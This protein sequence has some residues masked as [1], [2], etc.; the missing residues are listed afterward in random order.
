MNKL[1]IPL[2]LAS[3]AV[4]AG[5]FFGGA[6]AV[7]AA[8]DSAGQEPA[9]AAPTPV[10]DNVKHTPGDIDTMIMIHRGWSV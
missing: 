6:I 9:V 8:P 7:M 2:R 10:M 5:A 1:R 4:V 3:A